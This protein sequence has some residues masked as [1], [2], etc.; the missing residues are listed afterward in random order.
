MAG[1]F[2]LK[3]N[4]TTR[5]IANKYREGKLKRTK[6]LE[7]KVHEIDKREQLAR[8]EGRLVIGI[9]FAMA[10][11]VWLSLCNASRCAVFASSR[12]VLY[13]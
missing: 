10:T 3:L 13:H 1:K 8:T 2:Q 11:R 12:L 6:K 9:G 4:I 5:P 7:S